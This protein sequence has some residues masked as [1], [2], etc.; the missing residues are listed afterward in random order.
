M[1]T[2][3]IYVL[4]LALLILSSIMLFRRALKLLSR[5]ERPANQGKVARLLH[6]PAAPMTELADKEEIV[7]RLEREFHSSPSMDF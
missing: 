7:A 1:A 4:V 2:S 5:P 3:V 6:T